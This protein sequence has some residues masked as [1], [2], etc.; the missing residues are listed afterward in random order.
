[1]TSDER[2]DGDLAAQIA[3]YEIP[4]ASIA[5]F[6]GSD[7]AVDAA[8]VLDAES[9]APVH[10]DSI[11]EIGSVTKV[12]TA[13]LILQLADEGILDLDAPVRGVLPDFRIA[14]ADAAARVTP[15]HLLTH[16]GGFEGDV[17]A[18]T[19]EG[20]ESLELFLAELADA[21]QYFSPG[22]MFSYSNAGFC[23]LGRIVE[24]LTGGSYDQALADRVISPLGLTD[25]HPQYAAALASRTAKGHRYGDDGLWTPTSD[26][27]PRSWAPAG[28]RLAMT[29]ADLA[30]FGVAHIRAHV[31]G[32]PLGN[33]LLAAS[34][35]DGM[36][37]KQP[38]AVP[39]LAGQWPEFRGLGW[40]IDDFD[41]TI[42]LGHDGDTI[43]QHAFLRVI[44][45]LDLAVVALTNGGNAHAWFTEF[46][47]NVLVRETGGRIA[48]S[49]GAGRT[50]APA[51]ADL[52]GSYAG[53]SV[54]WT[55]SARPEGGLTLLREPQG[56]VAAFQEPSV[57]ELVHVAGRTFVTVDDDPVAYSFLGDSGPAIYLHSGR[58]YPRIAVHA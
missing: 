3:R 5:V 7:L 34:S 31:S 45:S 47:E 1:M 43:G 51:P 10:P 2:Y 58:A 24:V 16:S 52:V 54:R 23:V 18:D 20:E 48:R 17:F 9:A 8:G 25:A 29:A 38:V 30:R 12:W 56:F 40:E 33:A 15:R 27:L 46:F 26:R 44:P 4:G 57:A 32:S 19:G 11:F 6:R 49:S 55:V 50:P 39:D 36:Q 22:E 35:L 14:D 41:G 53:V 21:P 42:V 28:T 13:T 37:T